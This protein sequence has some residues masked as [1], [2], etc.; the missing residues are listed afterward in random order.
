MLTREATPEMVAEW[1]AIHKE[2]SAKIKP[3]RKS[4]SELAAFLMAKYPLAELKDEAA[5]SVVTENVLN[6]EH[7]SQKLKEGEHPSPLAFFVENTGDG[8]ALYEK[9]DEIF[10]GSKVFVG[11]DLSSGLYC[12]EGS[13]LLWDELCAFQGLDEKDLQNCFCVAQYVLALERF[14]LKESFIK[15]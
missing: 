6:N 3:N 14:G 7:F 9:Q 2:Y 5:L 8:A 13:S 1:K 15:Y 11:I 4:G 10:A 12:I